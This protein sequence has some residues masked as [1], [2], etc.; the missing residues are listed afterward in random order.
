MDQDPAEGWLL[1]C[2][3]CAG[4]RQPKEGGGADSPQRMGLW[5]GKLEERGRAGRHIRALLIKGGTWSERHRAW[6]YPSW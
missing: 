6:G 1:T 3:P 2:L 4:V 5:T